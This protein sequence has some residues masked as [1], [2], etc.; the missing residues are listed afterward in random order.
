MAQGSAAGREDCLE[1]IW[2]RLRLLAALGLLLALTP[3]V[4]R[5]HAH[6][7]ADLPVPRRI[8]YDWMTVD[9]W[10]DHHVRL[11]AARDQA[12]ASG[13][14]AVRLVWLGD[15]ITEWWPRVGEDSWREHWLPRAS[16]NLGLG[17]DSTQHL[18]WRLRHG[19]LDGLQPQVVVL[20]VGTNNLHLSGHDEV[21]VVGGIEAVVAELR[22]QLPDIAIVVSAILPRGRRASDPM[23]GR[24]Q[25]I[26]AALEQRLAGR[27]NI[28]FIDAGPLMLEDDG[29]IDRSIMRD[30]LHLT[31]AGYR[32]WAEALL[33]A[34]D[35]ALAR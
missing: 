6:E 2:A 4:A 9:E 1:S 18:L 20:A 8:D 24:I 30:Y 3:T 29:G 31:D 7:A 28:T 33:P 11:L 14:E 12:V 25:V 21:T 27:E 15:S 19:A 17:G 10:H 16:I 35:A 26:N 13:S 34:I 23:R 22:Q 5:E 32:R